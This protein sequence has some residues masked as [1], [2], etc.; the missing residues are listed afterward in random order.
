MTTIVEYLSCTVDNGVAT[1]VLNHPPVNALT[2]PH[3]HT[4]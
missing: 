4:A 1:L 2:P 3:P